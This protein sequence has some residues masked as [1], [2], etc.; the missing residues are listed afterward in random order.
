MP[1]DQAC[2]RMQ[3]GVVCVEGELTVF[4]PQIVHRGPGFSASDVAAGHGI[5]KL[6]EAYT[7]F[8]DLFRLCV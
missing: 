1:V 5:K 7:V 3:R 2:N 8:N 4:S 6:L